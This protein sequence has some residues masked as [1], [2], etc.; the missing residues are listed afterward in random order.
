MLPPLPPAMLN[1]VGG[2]GFLDFVQKSL[3]VRFIATQVNYTIILKN[4]DLSC[5]Q[6]RAR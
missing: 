6:G 3:V 2:Q 4:E 5:M 1:G